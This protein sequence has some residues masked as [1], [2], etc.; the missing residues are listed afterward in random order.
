M[1]SQIIVGYNPNDFFYSDAEAQGTMPT[2]DECSTIY[3]PDSTTIDWATKCN[4]SNFQITNN[5]TISGKVSSGTNIIT[6]KDSIAKDSIHIGALVIANAGVSPDGTV[7]KSVDEQNK[8]IFIS[9]NANKNVT[10][11]SDFTFSLNNGNTCISKELCR[12]K[13]YVEQLVAIENGHS[14][15]D[16][17]YYNTKEQYNEL[18]MSTM[19]LGIGCLFLGYAIYMNK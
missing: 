6:T 13:T 17:K 15:A 12:N 16:E 5:L 11:F 8:K 1:S 14:G 10:T 7:V 3:N 4:E 18:F 19:N 2:V 9:N